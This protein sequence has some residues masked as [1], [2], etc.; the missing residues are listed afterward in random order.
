MSYCLGREVAVLG[1]ILRMMRPLTCQS[2]Q[3]CRQN[4]ST[5]A[6]T[7]KLVLQRQTAT[8]I[9]SNRATAHMGPRR[10]FL[11][12]LTWDA[13]VMAVQRETGIAAI[14]KATNMM[15]LG[16][17]THVP[18]TRGDCLLTRLT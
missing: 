6:V 2:R 15:Y 4:N 13:P 8:S 3:R 9:I 12:T 5:F 7:V 16:L 1:K 18:K 11:T 10:G 14:T 17:S